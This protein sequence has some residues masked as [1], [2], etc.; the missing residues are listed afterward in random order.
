MSFFPLLHL[1]HC[2][3]DGWS[4]GRGSPLFSSADLNIVEKSVRGR[5]EV[6]DLSPLSITY[7]ASVM[8]KNSC[9]YDWYCVLDLDAGHLTVEIMASDVRVEF[10]F[11]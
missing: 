1:Q 4:L 9:S 7:L 2:K 10:S 3:V 8:K 6:C 11:G 5:F